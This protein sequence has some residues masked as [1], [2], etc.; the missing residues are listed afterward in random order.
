M[1]KGIAVILS[2][3]LT[4][5]VP[6]WAF[7]DSGIPEPENF[8]ASDKEM[9]ENTTDSSKMI[10]TDTSKLSDVY[11]LIKNDEAETMD[12]MISD[13]AKESFSDAINRLCDFQPAEDEEVRG[14]LGN[15]E[16]FVN[17]GALNSYLGTGNLLKGAAIGLT[18]NKEEKVRVLGTEANAE[19]WV[20]VVDKDAMSWFVKGPDGMGIPNALVSISY[21]DD[22][23]KRVNKSV[24]ATAGNTPGIAVFDGIPEIFSGIVDIQADGYR[25]ISI[26][27]K[28]MGTGKHFTIEMTE[29]KPNELYVRGVDLSGKDMLNEDTTLSLVNM[30]TENLTLKVLV[31]KSGSSEFPD[32]IDIRSDN[33]S[34]TVLTVNKSEAFPYASDTMVYTASKRWVEQSSGLLKDN[35]EVSIQFGGGSFPLEHV[36]VENA[37]AAPG[38]TKEDEVPVTTKSLDGNVADRLSGS[39]M[40]NQTLQILKVPVTF[41]VFPDGTMIFMA[42]YDFTSLAPEV[43]SK[44]S[45]LFQKSWN[46]KNVSKLG[47]PLE[48]FEKSFWENAEK[49]KKAQ[50]ILDSPRKIKCVSNPNYDFQLNFSIFLRTCYNKETDDYYGSGGFMF[51]GGISA[52]VTEYFLLPAG[53]IVIPAYIG[54]EGHAYLNTTLAVDFA[55]DKPPEGHV[56]EAKWKYATK[57]GWD[58]NGRIEIVIGCSVFGG[59]GV[60][61]VLGA[62]A[63]GY[64]DFDIATVI[65]KGGRAFGDPHSFIDVLYGLRFEY[66]L[67]FYS[68]TINMDC[69]KGAERLADSDGQYDA[70]MEEYLKAVEEMEFTNIPLEECAEDLDWKSSNEP[71]KHDLMAVNEQKMVQL[72]GSSDTQHIEGNLYPDTQVQFAATQNYTGLFRLASNGRRTDIIYQRYD[73][74]TG[75]PYSGLYAVTLP[76]GESRSVSEFVVVPNKTNHSDK[77]YI[78]AIL[79]D[80]NQSD[81]AERMKSSDVVAAVVDLDETYTTSSVIAS[82]P[83]MKGKYCYS[84]PKP[85]GRDDI[86]AVAFAATKIQ[87]ENGTQVQGLK[88]LLKTAQDN[89]EFYLSWGEDGDQ[90]KR[91]VWNLGTNKV[92][93]TG[94]ISPNEP[95]YW[96]A[97]PI[98]STDKTLV[99][100]GYGANGYYDKDS[101]RC[102]FSIDIT[103]MITEE[104][105]KSGSAPFDSIISNW[106]YMNGCNYFVG[107]DSI[108]WMRKSSNDPQNYRWSAEKLKNGSGVISADNRY[109][110]ITN[111]EQSALYL[112]GVVGDYDVNVEEGEAAKG[113][114]IA[115]IY[116]ITT[117]RDWDTKELKSS[118]LH[119]PLDLKFAKGQT[120]NCFTAAY[121]PPSAGTSGLSIVYSTPAQSG[122]RYASQLYMWH[123]NGN[124]GL[125]VTDLKIP[126]YRVIEGQPYIELYATLHNYGYTIENTAQFKVCDENNNTLHQVIIGTDGKIYDADGVFYSIDELYAGDACVKKLLIRP[127]ADWSVNAEHKVI[128]DLTENCKYNGDVDDVLNSADMKADNT[129]MTAKTTLVGGK[130]MLSISITNNTF[131]GQERPNVKITPYYGTSET[132]GRTLK[133]GLPVREKILRFDIPEDDTLDQHELT[134]QIYHYDINVDSIFKEGKENGLLGIYVSLVDDEG[135]RVSNEEL[136]L[137]NPEYVAPEADPENEYGEDGTPLGRGASF[138]AADKAIKSMKKDKDP[139]GTHFAP[140]RLNSR[141]QTKQSITLSWKKANNA[142]KYVIYG[143]LS[144]NGKKMTKLA[145]L[146]GTAKTLKSIAGKKVAKGKSYKFMVLALDGDNKVVSTSKLIHVAAAGGKTGNYKKVT[147]KAKGGKVT[148]GK[149]RTFRLR[150]KGIQAARKLK[151]KVRVKMR[152]ES[153]NPKI[154]SVNAKGVIKAKKKGTCKVYSYA[155]NGVAKTVKVTVK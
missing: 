144:G 79:A 147:T 19:S 86:C 30:D 141:K 82:D 16:G 138:E 35:D 27:D 106:Q 34:K 76:E 134:D 49:V 122:S 22:S 96:M 135:N 44:Y 142:K 113:N 54:F 13:E 112:I 72:E 109:A 127:G 128:V 45:G 66:Y 55:M 99:V 116:T 2:L 31:T 85:A 145:E 153:S 107:G 102:N 110:M 103:G 43:Q 117:E 53:P 81:E 91:T 67:L 3:I 51:S 78:G 92:H 1:R 4:L 98:R 150:A 140:L 148:I 126:E 123:Q 73:P 97:D 115:K 29:S 136:Y 12:S 14:V 121:N 69:L 133:F 100:K 152:F 17:S 139:A 64:V 74:L 37:V 124:K 95:S 105:I 47:D 118:T 62:S 18:E 25:A 119:G 42:S 131:V 21:L 48:V 36:K 46:P 104:Q 114:N 125:L 111:N 7:A 6:A 155:Q 50:K 41:G 28:E 90:E 33:R 93:S 38:L 24:T 68:G 23:G 70:F 40:I 8:P 59:V 9:I 57:D 39:G 129:T 132:Q 80:I 15:I 61:G 137:D 20:F 143:N 63:T 71:G 120:I 89:T 26:L 146:K 75:K 84:A 56:S 151:V 94:A 11:G 87:T 130:H 101:G 60:K 77:V 65:G 154:A 88:D 5:S 108:Y 10:K 32:S 52:G 58:V 83:N 149:G